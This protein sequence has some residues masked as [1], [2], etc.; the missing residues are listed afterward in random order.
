M[1]ERMG[2]RERPR[3]YNN[4]L[5]CPERIGHS[6]HNKKGDEGK[7]DMTKDEFI[8]DYSKFGHRTDATHGPGLHDDS[9]RRWNLNKVQQHFEAVT[10]DCGKRECQGWKMKA[11]GYPAPD[12]CSVDPMTMFGP[13]GP[14]FTMMDPAEPTISFGLPD[15]GLASKEPIG[16]PSLDFPF[17]WSFILDG[18]T[19]GELTFNDSTKR[20]EFSGNADASV[21]IL[22]DLVTDQFEA[23]H[24][25]KYGE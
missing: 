19:V 10:C 11:I 1:A 17:H 8:N 12:D 14:P 13:L 2:P 24:K 9:F 3:E 23:W 6:H 22:F 4:V 7:N 20:L 18:N 25:E 16:L 15:S 21:K 5:G